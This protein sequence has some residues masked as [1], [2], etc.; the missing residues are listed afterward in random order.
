MDQV[1]ALLAGY[2]FDVLLGSVH[3]LGRGCST[4]SASVVA[5]AGVG[6][7]RGRRRVGRLHRALEELAATGAVDVLAHPDLCKVTGRRPGVPDEWYDRM[8]EAAAAAGMA[9]EVSSAGYRKPVGRALP[10]AAAARRFHR[11]GV[12]VTT[13]SDAHRARRTWPCAPRTCAPSWPAPGTRVARSTPPDAAARRPRRC[14]SSGDDGGAGPH[15]HRPGRGR[16]LP[17]CSGWSPTGGCC[18]TSASPTCCCTPTWPA[19]MAAGSWCSARSARPPTRPSTARTCVG[20]IIDE[21]ERPFVARAWRLGE[22]VEGELSRHA[23]RRA[24]PPPVHPR[25]HHDRLVAVMSRSR[26]R[27]VG[28]TLGE[29]ERVYVETFDRFARMIVG[30]RVPLRER[31]IPRPRTAPGGRRRGGARRAAAGRVRLARTR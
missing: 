13:A 17:I 24:G 4:T 1:A 12:P 8:A 5:M 15:A 2:P 18:R 19:A 23:R 22:I 9:A 10:P 25:R 14:R 11:R 20:R 7:P 30:G 6:R 29:L 31:G 27:R 3:W 28:R 26:R 16:D 21:V